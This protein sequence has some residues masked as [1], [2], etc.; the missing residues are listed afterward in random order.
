MKTWSEHSK[1]GLVKIF[2]QIKAYHIGSIK[3]N[4]PMAPTILEIGLPICGLRLNH[5][6]KYVGD[7]FNS[8][9]WSRKTK[10]KSL[11]FCANSWT[12]SWTNTFLDFERTVVQFSVKKLVCLCSFYMICCNYS[13]IWI[14]RSFI[15]P[16][17]TFRSK[18]SV[19][20]HEYHWKHK[21]KLYNLQ[22]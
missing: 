5:V 10:K 20:I 12:S 11:R 21:K 6:C 18:E 17:I 1:A 14:R 9:K 8:A 15:P 13:I 2:S 16:F 3:K 4:K 7:F 22:P 19:F